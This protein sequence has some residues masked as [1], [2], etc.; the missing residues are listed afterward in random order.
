MASIVLFFWKHDSKKNGYQEMNV[1]YKDD[2]KTE[3]KLMLVTNESELDHLV[4]KFDLD[5]YEES[6]YKIVQGC[7]VTDKKATFCYKFDSE[8]YLTECTIYVPLFGVKDYKDESNFDVEHYSSNDIKTQ[9]KRILLWLSN[10]FE[11]DLNSKEMIISKDGDPLDK[12]DKAYD[13]VKN[14]D[15]IIRERFI[16]S[17]GYLWEIKI[18]K[19]EYGILQCIIEKKVPGDDFDESLVDVIID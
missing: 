15:A 2:G 17:N 13:E 1:T 10:L 12:N 3:S 8:E 5:V 18:S 16:D 4:D 7:S 19:A 14:N 6:N 9:T 11:T